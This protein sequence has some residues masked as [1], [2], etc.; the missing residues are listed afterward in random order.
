MKSNYVLIRDGEQYIV[1]IRKFT[2]KEYSTWEH[3]V[4]FHNSLDSAYREAEKRTM[5][6]IETYQNY[7][8]KYKS[9]RKKNEI[10]G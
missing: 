8:Q 9:K 3:F 7:I 10:Y 1:M 2:K 5:Y 6:K 4:S